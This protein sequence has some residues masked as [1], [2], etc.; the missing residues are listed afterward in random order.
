VLLPLL[1][2]RYTVSIP[3]WILLLG[4][5]LA[6]LL[7]L[8][9]ISF[10]STRALGFVVPFCAAGFYMGFMSRGSLS[11]RIMYVLPLAGCVAH[12]FNVRAVSFLM[13][14]VYAGFLGLC[15]DK[16]RSETREVPVNL[17]VAIWLY[18]GS[19]ALSLF[20][21]LISFSR[22]LP[23]LNALV[24]SPPWGPIFLK[25][26]F[27]WIVLALLVS[28]AGVAFFILVQE[29]KPQPRMLVRALSV[30][31]LVAFAVGLY[32]SMGG[33]FTGTAD[34]FIMPGF[35]RLSRYN[36]TFVDP[37]VLGIVAA[38]TLSL[39]AASVLT[40]EEHRWR[41]L[42]GPALVYLIIVSGSRTALGLAT[43]TLLCLAARMLK[44][45]RDVVRLGFIVLSVVGVG[46][47][48]HA[49]G[50]V[51]IR[52]IDYAKQISVNRDFDDFV[53][54]VL[55]DRRFTLENGLAVF[56]HNPVFGVGL[57]KNRENEI[58][59]TNKDRAIDPR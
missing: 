50:L 32:Q 7:S 58:K 57:G 46:A 19:I 43:F 4:S 10:S 51:N 52:I 41:W 24:S 23:N 45:R 3:A 2:K 29:E 28:I 16:W 9:L 25:N 48:I 17:P 13:P 39:W 6:V 55:W 12:I 8:A 37:N 31:M 18:L 22:F 26:A 38:L 35:P 49:T 59:A 15:A 54:T 5:G 20:V 1:L 21:A 47:L 40:G 56:Y 30:S 53:A 33:P 44:S 42:V 36:A 27:G 14:F 11:T 34:S